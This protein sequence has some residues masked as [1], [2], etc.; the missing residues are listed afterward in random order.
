MQLSVQN[1]RFLDNTECG[2]Y[3]AVRELK[4]RF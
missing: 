3:N 2:Q 1:L 4:L